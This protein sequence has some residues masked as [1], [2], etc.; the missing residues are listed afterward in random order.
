MGI[1]TGDLPACS[2]VPQLRYRVPQC[3]IGQVN[4]TSDITSTLNMEPIHFLEM[5]KPLSHT[6][7]SHSGRLLHNLFSFFHLRII[8]LFHQFQH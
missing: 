4:M 1:R 7:L 2:T 5:F 3:I 8:G 6:I